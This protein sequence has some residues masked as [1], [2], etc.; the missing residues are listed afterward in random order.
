VP[1]PYDKAAADGLAR[2]P[3][4]LQVYRELVE[5]SVLLDLLKKDYGRRTFVSMGTGAIAPKARKMRN[6]REVQ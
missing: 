1:E 6:S 3:T 4:W 2:S 5:W